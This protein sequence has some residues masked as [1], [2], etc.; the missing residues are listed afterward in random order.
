MLYG[1]RHR[2][3]RRWLTKKGGETPL[4]A[5]ARAFDTEEEALRA[6]VACA[7]PEFWS[8]EP[9]G[10]LR[11]GEGSVNQKTAAWQQVEIMQNRLNK[12]AATH[13]PAL[14]TVYLEAVGQFNEKERGSSAAADAWRAAEAAQLALNDDARL[15][16]PLIARV[17]D[18]RA[19]LDEYVRIGGSL[20]RVPGVGG[21]S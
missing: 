14:S 4:E 6:P 16:A 9:L 3:S 12:A 19:A 11:D 10:V 20:D 2:T 15:C 8:A 13:L 21:L 18:L 17:A 7:A 5:L 1:L